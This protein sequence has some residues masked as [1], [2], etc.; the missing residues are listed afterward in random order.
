M[1]RLRFGRRVLMS[2]AGIAAIVIPPAA[3]IAV[4]IFVGRLLIFSGGAHLVLAW[5]SRE[6]EGALWE[7][8]LGILYLFTCGYLLIN[9][10]LGLASLTLP[11]AIYLLA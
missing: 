8:L 7:V 6:S 11:L 4:T 5:H 1:G 10:V 9:P 3:G 2:L